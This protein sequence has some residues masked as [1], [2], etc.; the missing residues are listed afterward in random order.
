MNNSLEQRVKFP[1]HKSRT[2][3]INGGLSH[4]VDYRSLDKKQV[5]GWFKRCLEDYPVN[6]MITQDR[7]VE[8]VEDWKEKWFS[9]FNSSDGK[10]KQDE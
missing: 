5:M 2:D 1:T 10:V 6:Y 4:S 7:W 3:V 8:Q 9:Q